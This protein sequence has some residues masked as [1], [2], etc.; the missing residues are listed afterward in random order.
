MIYLH[1]HSNHL[2]YIYDS[3][4]GGTFFSSIFAE[5]TILYNKICI[6]MERTNYILFSHRS[7]ADLPPI[8]IGRSAIEISVSL[9]LL[10]VMVDEHLTFKTMF[11]ISQKKK[12]GSVDNLNKLKFYL[13]IEPLK[14]IHSAFILSYLNYTIDIWYVGYKNVTERMFIL[15]KKAINDDDDCP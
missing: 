9:K 12:S 4:D 3:L 13:P 15:Q 14:S 2:Q 6:N 10:G 11:N 8:F 1:V 7:T 5:H